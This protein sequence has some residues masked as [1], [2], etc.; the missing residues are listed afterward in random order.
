MADSTCVMPKSFSPSPERQGDPL[1]ALGESVSFGRFMTETLDW[2]KWSTFNQNRYLEEAQRFSRPGLVA[3]KKALFEAHFKKIA[4]DRAAALLEAANTD[5]KNEVH[6]HG[7]R[8]ET[9][10]GPCMDLGSGESNCLFSLD[11]AQSS[12]DSSSS[13]HLKKDVSF[14]ES[15]S[16]EAY[17]YKRSDTTTEISEFER[18]NNCQ[19]AIYIRTNEPSSDTAADAPQNIELCNKVDLLSDTSKCNYVVVEPKSFK[20]FDPPDDLKTEMDDLNP[21]EVGDNPTMLL[22]LCQEK[23]AV[24]EPIDQIVLA[25]TGK[26]KATITGSKTLAS[27]RKPAPQSYSKPRAQALPRKENNATESTGSFGGGLSNK[28]GV[29]TKSL[30]MSISLDS[31]L[32]DSKRALAPKKLNRAK[33]PTNSVSFKGSKEHS[34]QVTPDFVN[35]KKMTT[36]SRS[37]TTIRKSSAESFIRPALPQVKKDKAITQRDRT[38]MRNSVDIRKSSHKSLH[39]SINFGSYAE[40]KKRSMSYQMAGT[41][42][43][44]TSVRMSKT[45]STHARAKQVTLE[46]D[47]TTR[48]KETIPVS[49]TSMFGRKLITQIHGK[50]TPTLDKS[51]NIARG[52]SDLHL[53]QIS[54]KKSLPKSLHMSVDLSSTVQVV[55]P[56]IAQKSGSSSYNLA[57]VSASRDRSNQLQVSL[58]KSMQTSTVRLLDDKGRPGTPLNCIRPPSPT[59]TTPFRFRSD[60]RAAKRKEKFEEQKKFKVDNP[61]QRKEKEKEKNDPRKLRHSI[62]FPMKPIVDGDDRNENLVSHELKLPPSRPQSPMYLRKPTLGKAQETTNY[63]PPRTPGT[64]KGGSLQV[65]QNKIQAFTASITSLPSKITCENASP[66]IEI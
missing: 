47:T 30:H 26:Y 4:A 7:V 58:Q 44:T 37:L 20:K 62:N 54:R 33:N 3:Q 52:N 32:P 48:R 24:Q 13:L 34:D 46:S 27:V 53:S 35:P 29:V 55:K 36:S 42:S 17:N 45:N 51:E 6:R 56:T 59:V 5:V 15:Q 14:V 57:A 22:P 9:L 10:G 49:N 31:I 12:S 63:R 28:K 43:D 25:S 50:P 40:G 39:S 38:S 19:P 66:N 16:G 21:S 18:V 61:L 65:T 64:R 60:E 8:N 23:V 41:K 2:E 11:A 1:R